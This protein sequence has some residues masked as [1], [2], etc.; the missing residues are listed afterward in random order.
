MRTLKKSILALAA[1]VLVLSLATPL[2]AQTVPDPTAMARRMARHF[3]EKPP[4]QFQSLQTA[5]HEPRLVVT[6]LHQYALTAFVAQTDPT[7]ANSIT[8]TAVYDVLT[9]VGLLAPIPRGLSFVTGVLHVVGQSV[10][11][12]YSQRRRSGKMAAPT[13][14]MTC[15]PESPARARLLRTAMTVPSPCFRPA[16]TRIGAEPNS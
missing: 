6:N 9:R 7:A 1:G 5:E 2:P 3:S 8:N 11:T 4:V 12:P 15:S 10:Q 14:R 16:W 13:G